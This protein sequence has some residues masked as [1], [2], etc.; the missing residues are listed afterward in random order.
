MIKKLR[1]LNAKSMYLLILAA[2]MVAVIFAAQQQV[3]AQDNCE[4]KRALEKFGCQGDNAIQGYQQGY[5][6][7]KSA[8]FNGESSSCP[9][10]DSTSGYCLGWGAGYNKGQDARNTQNEVQNSDDGEIVNNDNDDD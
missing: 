7:G 5:S 9:Q 3:K 10:S 2:S 6:D 4:G 8:G 1:S